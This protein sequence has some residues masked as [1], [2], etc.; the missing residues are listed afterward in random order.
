VVGG[1]GM[2]ESEEKRREE[3]KGIRRRKE[4]NKGIKEEREE[5]KRKGKGW[6]RK[7]CEIT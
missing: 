5:G 3:K 2:P 6:E 7:V 4:R 1:A